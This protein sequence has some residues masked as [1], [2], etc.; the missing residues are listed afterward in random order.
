MLSSD[1][2]R[3]IPKDDLSN[4]EKLLIIKQN[5]LSV[6]DV[7]ARNFLLYDLVSRLLEEKLW[8]KAEIFTRLMETWE[9]ERSWFLGDIAAQIWQDGNTEQ[10]HALFAEAIKLVHKNGRDWQS[11][12]ALLRIA[13][14][15]VELGER[16]IATA[17]LLESAEIAQRGEKESLAINN[18]QDAY[19]SSG[20]LREVAETLASFGEIDKAMQI[21]QTIIIDSR[22]EA[23][24][25]KIKKHA[26]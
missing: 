11:A 3:R 9:L 4:P 15:Y 18:P 21:A 10:A 5:I 14:H 8:H 1:E 7:D 22:R 24:L 26:S 2:I 12:E 17:I 25:D 20:V 16:N 19:D 23:A 6:D 13:N